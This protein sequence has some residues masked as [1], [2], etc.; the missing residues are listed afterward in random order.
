MK[1]EL[2]ELLLMQILLDIFI[3]LNHS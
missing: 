2:L 1:I 3:V